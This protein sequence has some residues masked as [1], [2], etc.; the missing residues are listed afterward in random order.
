ME[1]EENSSSV[2]ENCNTS[3]SDSSSN[4]DSELEAAVSKVKQ[5]M[6]D[7]TFTEQG[8]SKLDDNHRTIRRVTRSMKADS[9]SL[10]ENTEERI[11]SP[12]QNIT[13]KDESAE[14]FV[15]DKTPHTQQESISNSINF[16]VCDSEGNLQANELQST[17]VT[18]ANQ[19]EEIFI[20]TGSANPAKHSSYTLPSYIDAGIDVSDT[21]FV[22]PE[23]AAKKAIRGK[24]R[25][26]KSIIKKFT[27][28][29][30]LL[31]K[32][33]IK[34]GF[35][36]QE[37]VPT[38]Q[39]SKKKITK[40]KKEEREKTKGK[41]WFDMPKT[42]ITDEVKRELQVIHMRRA[43][44]P[45]HFYKGNDM[46]GMPKYFQ[47]GKVIESS[48]DFYSSRI[49]K[50]DRKQSLVDELMADAQFRQYNKRK[51]AEVMA[52]SALTGNRGAKKHMKRLKSKK[53]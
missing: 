30:E 20:I 26:G 29:S 35:E 22:D 31:I 9:Q 27:Q 2:D 13:A 45:K 50:K 6:T 40:Q 43:L 33:N 46:K 51:Y 15:I 32:S 10:R 16:D 24:P 25:V 41:K 52:A 44:D 14:I 28:T 17:N 49:P 23:R 36:K 47:M 3:D 1:D 19:D 39:E 18:H 38:H 4:S 37:S 5:A 8:V 12:S 34:P 7:T 48:A 21:Y 42:E 53:K 11:D